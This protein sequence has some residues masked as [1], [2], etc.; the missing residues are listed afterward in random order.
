MAEK[1]FLY[2][3]DYQITTQ[4]V[5]DEISLAFS[6]SGCPLHCKGCHSAFTWNET[7]GQELTNDLFRKILAENKYASCV[8]FYGGEWRLKRLLELIGIAK[9]NGKK[10]CLYTGLM[11]EEVKAS[12]SELFNVLDYIKVG[13]WIEEKGGLNK[14]TTNQRFYR[15]LNLNLCNNDKDRRDNLNEI[16]KNNKYNMINIDDNIIL[17]DWTKRFFQS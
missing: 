1:E 14:K 6:I 12:K 8:L 4:D 11:L 7:F 16:E 10:V 3:S 2:S 17:F 15:I 13:R 5:L 9:S